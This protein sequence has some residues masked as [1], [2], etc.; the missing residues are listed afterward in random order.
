LQRLVMET[1]RSVMWRP[2]LSV[3]G[4]RWFDAP[5]AAKASIYGTHS[6]RKQTLNQCNARRW[7]RRRK[8][9]NQW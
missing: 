1:R 2:N 4:I 5:F 3:R 9:A 8:R 6:A 7:R